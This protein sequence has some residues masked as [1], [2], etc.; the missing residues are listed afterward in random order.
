MQKLQ[1]Q[2]SLDKK[3]ELTQKGGGS[4]D[5]TFSMTFWAQCFQSQIWMNMCHFLSKNENIGSPNE[6][7][8]R[9]IYRSHFLYTIFMHMVKVSHY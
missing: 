1:K 4:F 9:G 6:C 7:V 3:L 8:F 5:D 2:G